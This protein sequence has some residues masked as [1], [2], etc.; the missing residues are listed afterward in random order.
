MKHK[1]A[2][3]FPPENHKT[4][5][6]VIWI[7]LLLIPASFAF[8]GGEVRSYRFGLQDCIDY[9]L[10]NHTVLL[11]QRLSQFIVKK[12]LLEAYGQYFPQVS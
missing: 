2:L 1:T 6:P 3:S 10:K 11:N 4:V 5:L 9:A 7:M 8:A 12:N